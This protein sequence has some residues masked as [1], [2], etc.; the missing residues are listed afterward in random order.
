MNRKYKKQGRK[1][2]TVNNDLDAPMNHLK[3]KQGSQSKEVVQLPE[4]V[5]HQQEKLSKALEKVAVREDTLNRKEQELLDKETEIKAGLP[6]LIAE[7]MKKQKE[8]IKK[9]ESELREKENKVSE[10]REQIEQNKTYIEKELAKCNSGFLELKSKQERELIGLK[11]KKLIEI[12]NEIG[13]LANERQAN[14]QQKLD[15]LERANEENI[16]NKK[17]EFSKKITQKEDELQAERNN[18]T[19]E[20]AVNEAL[21]HKLA[22]QELSLEEKIE[23]IDEEI[24]EKLEDRERS[25]EVKISGLKDEN[26]RLLNSIS[27]ADA[28]MSLY[29]ELKQQLGGESPE[30]IL[31]K[32]NAYQEKISQLKQELLVDPSAEIKKI[33]DDAKH[34]TERL[35]EK[36]EK[37]SQENIDLQDLANESSNKDLEIQ[38]YKLKLQSS[39]ELNIVRSDVNNL[40]RDELDHLTASNKSVQNLEDRLKLINSPVFT[41][42]FKRSDLQ[43]NSLQGLKNE[44]SDIFTELQWLDNIY[45]SAKEYGL[46]FS[47]RILYAFH[48]AIKTAE[49]SPITVL[50]G[51]SGTGKSELPRLYSYFGGINF[52]NV[53]VQPNWDCHESLIGYFNSIDNCFDAK[54]VL[55]LLAQSQQM[56]PEE[57]IKVNKKKF[58]DNKLDEKVECEKAI[59][60]GEVSIEGMNDVVNIVLLDEMNL[61]HIELYFADFLSKLEERR[62]KLAKNLPAI[63]IKLGA[64]MD[65]PT[66]KIPL[67]RNVLWVGTMNQ[68]ET[69]KS[70]SDKVLDRGINIHFPRPKTLESRKELK[71]LSNPTALLPMLEWKK[72]GN[73]KCNLPNYLSDKYRKI[74]EKI[75]DHLASVGKALG[76]RVWQSI[77]YYINNYPL[78]KA[79]EITKKIKNTSG[80]IEFVFERYSDIHQ[81]ERAAHLAFED[82]LVQK[83]MPKL[84]GIETRGLGKRKCLD[85]IKQ[86]LIDND[87]NIIE[88]FGRACEFGFGQFIWSSSEYLND[89]SALNELLENSIEGST[90]QSDEIEKLYD[91]YES[92][93]EDLWNNLDKEP[94]EL[95]TKEIEDHINISTDQADKMKCYLKVHL[96]PKS[97]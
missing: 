95:T 40:L 45:E 90:E 59:K 42:H 52:L 60:R 68:D 29:A 67:G 80:K 11:Q 83:I 78:V 15:E 21:K 86:L 81:L 5:E 28:T 32:L 56:I 20:Q 65:P 58:Q 37:S 19:E 35:E 73:T 49:F 92:K 26:K 75:N 36:L 85:P 38:Q 79:L 72:W 30:E 53:P 89:E 51:V 97:E 88:D 14:L 91:K 50:S 41:K 46:T 25:F 62:G 12:E 7:Q 6:A 63:E 93:L 8:L 13:E 87:F 31:Q 61:A 18:L 70:L 77:E 44:S 23:H 24:D 64:K 54:P 33:A 76:H 71:P 82:Q 1:D 48:T 55:N 96:K 43:L 84:R 27:K 94:S 39:D 16:K 57:Y 10:D 3:E 4:N 66:H 74:V 34:K 47:K 2:Q 69:T 9:N 17:I 22:R